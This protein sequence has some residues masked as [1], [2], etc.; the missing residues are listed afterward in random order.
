MKEVTRWMTAGS[1]GLATKLREP[2]AIDRI[3]ASLA[4]SAVLLEYVIADSDAYCLVISRNG[5]RIVRLGRRVQIDALVTS[6]LKVVKGKL[7]AT[8]EARDL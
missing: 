5:S 7:P 1:T 8:S 4:P 6:Y 3:N 2:V